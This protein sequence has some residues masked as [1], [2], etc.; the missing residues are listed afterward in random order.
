MHALLHPAQIAVTA[1]LVLW[2]ISGFTSRPGLWLR[3]KMFCRGT[4][5]I[6]TLTGTKDGHT[7]EVNPYKYLSP[8]SFLLSPARLQA[9]LTYLT[10]S[11][12][13]DRLDGTG[14]VLSVRGEQ[15]IE[16]TDSH[17]LVR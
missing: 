8:G 7:E 6:I 9:I 11:G 12:R 5:T 2:M 15:Q 4:F 3:W 14:R 16:V 1:A 13:Y 10:G 17:V